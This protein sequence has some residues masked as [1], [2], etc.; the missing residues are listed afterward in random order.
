MHVVLYQFYR[1]RCCLGSASGTRAKDFVV[2]LA[3]VSPQEIPPKFKESYAIC[4]QY[5]G[6]PLAAT[7]SL[8]C[9]VELPPF[10]Y[11]IVQLPSRTFLH[12]CE[13]QVQVRG[14][15]NVTVYLK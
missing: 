4:A 11:V 12:F 3:N 14:M 15:T 8:Y 10:R 5:D 13:L 7:V 2:G 1:M 9:D 6:P